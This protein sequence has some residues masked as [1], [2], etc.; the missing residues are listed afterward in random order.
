MKAFIDPKGKI[1]MFRPD[2]NA[3]RMR[4]SCERISL[5]DFEAKEMV[6]GIK[7][8]L[9]VDKSWI[10]NKPGFSMYIRPTAISMTDV[11][12]VRA[13]EDSLLFV[14]LSPVGPYYPTGFTPIS[15]Y[16]DQN[17]VRAYQGGSGHY[18]IGANYGPTIKIS[19]EAE[20]KGYNQILWL[21]GDLVTEVGTSNIFFFWKNEQGE[22][23]L[24]T[25]PLEG[26]VLPGIVRDS[27]LQL[28]RGL[29]RFKVTE[30]NFTIHEVTKAIKQ[31]R[32]YEA[33]GAGT[34]ATVSPIKSIFYDNVDYQVPIDEKVKAGKLAKQFNDMLLDIQY[35]KVD[36]PW[37]VVVD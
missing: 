32:L 11:L 13:P 22:D 2:R 4:T 15:L 31:G 36:H 24:I 7:K 17:I 8:L 9:I 18:K 19:R 33:F 21:T 3:E 10:P 34:A 16:T 28:A 12:G 6:E 29:N 5:P 30:R 27:V 23:E 20:L 26:L 14:V 35:G 37:S 1:R 25:A